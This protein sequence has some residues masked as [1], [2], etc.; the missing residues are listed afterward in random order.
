V[1]GPVSLPRALPANDA[2][3]NCGE[4]PDRSEV[5][6]G[7]HREPDDRA[8]RRR[9]AAVAGHE[10]DRRTARHLLADPDPGVRAVALGALARTGAVTAVDLR[11]AADDPAPGVRRRVAELLATGSPAGDDPVE[12][13]PIGPTAERPAGSAGA[14]A[15]DPAADATAGSAADDLGPVLWRLLDDSDVSVV[16]VAAWA[17]GERRPVAAGTADRLARLATGHEDSLVREAAVAAL[18]ALGDRTGLAAILAA[19]RDRATVRRR[20]VLALASFSGSDVDA[21]ITRA[22]TDRDAQVR[23]AGEDLS[24]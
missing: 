20:A 16:E 23:Q 6:L 13:L 3:Q 5:A 14:D 9:R 15:A 24:R 10:G 2:G 7:E 19:T 11:T 22:R 12:Q 17:C 21:A 18:G 8:V 4:L 1:A